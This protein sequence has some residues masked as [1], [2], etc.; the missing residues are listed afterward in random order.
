[1]LSRRASLKRAKKRVRKRATL[2]DKRK[3]RRIKTRRLTLRT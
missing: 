3:L 1:M 2:R